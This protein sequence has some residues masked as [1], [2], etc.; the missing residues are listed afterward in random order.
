[1]QDDPLYL[2]LHGGRD[3]LPPPEPKASSLREWVSIMC[4]AMEK[5]LLTNA[6]EY[7]AKEA[8][9]ANEGTDDQ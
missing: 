9:A 2:F 3:P 6:E 8:A 4:D 7:E 1:L 5:F